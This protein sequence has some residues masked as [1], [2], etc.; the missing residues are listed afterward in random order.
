M[1]KVNMLE[2]K[3]NLTKLVKLLESKE[4]DE[5]LICRNNE[6][7][8]RILRYER[9]KNKRIGIAKGKHKPLD[10]KEFNSMNEEIAKEF[11]GE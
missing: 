6:P 11:Y 8:A 7:V 2:A 4:E 1:M 5:I 3:T 10:L 9:P